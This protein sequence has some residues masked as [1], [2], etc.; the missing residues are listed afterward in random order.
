M[1]EF[2][3]AYTAQEIN[4][5]LGKIDDILGNGEVDIVPYTVLPATEFDEMTYFG[6]WGTGIMPAPATLNLGETY[7]VE[8][9]GDIYECP[10]QDASMIMEGVVGLGDGSIMGAE[11]NGEPFIIGIPEDMSGVMC[12]SLFDT[13]PTVHTV[14]IYQVKNKI[15]KVIDDY[16]GKALGGDY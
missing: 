9:N 8:W 5:K 13:E 16:I 4:E 6:F 15:E 12:L 14:R 10:A 7:I 3:L 1:A 2:R 11:G